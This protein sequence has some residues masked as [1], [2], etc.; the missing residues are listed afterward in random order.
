MPPYN[1]WSPAAPFSSR[2]REAMMVLLASLP[3]PE[4][5]MGGAFLVILFLA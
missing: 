3:G 5:T 1:C 4:L 2:L